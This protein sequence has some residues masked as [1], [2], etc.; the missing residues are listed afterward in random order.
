[1]YFNYFYGY[2]ILGSEEVV[3]Y[4][5]VQ[6]LWEYYQVYFCFDNLVISLVGW[7]IL[8]QVQDWVEISFGDW[9]ILE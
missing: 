5:I 8:V 3:F 4:F 9:V 7:L 1:M 6:D 2:F